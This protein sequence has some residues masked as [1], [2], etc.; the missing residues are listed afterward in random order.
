MSKKLIYI[1]GG[2]SF[3]FAIFHFSFWYLFDWP[4]S[5]SCL[6]DDN[7]GIMQSLALHC[8]ILVL[9][10][11]YLSIFHVKSLLENKMG[12]IILLLIALFWFLR[13]IEEIY[14]L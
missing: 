14:F 3:I 5:L 13:I 6:N 7:I 10:I 4:N 1:G 12:N 9:I 11:S 2:I 8:S